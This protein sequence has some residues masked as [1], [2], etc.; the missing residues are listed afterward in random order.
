MLSPCAASHAFW[1]CFSVN[2]MGFPPWARACRGQTRPRGAV[3]DAGDLRVQREETTGEGLR[4]DAVLDG[5]VDQLGVV[6]D[7]ERLHQALLVVLDGARGQAERRADLLR[8]L[9]LGEEPQDLAL[10]RRDGC[11]RVGGIPAAEDF[12]GEFGGDEGA[13]LQ[14]GAQRE[15][16][17]RRRGVL[18]HEA[19]RAGLERAPRVGRV[20][21]HGQEHHAHL[22]VVALELRER[23]DAVQLRHGDVGDDHVG[24]ELARRLYQ[25]A[26]VFHDTG[27]I[28]L[29]RQ[30]AL[31]P[32]GDDAMVVGQQHAGP[33]HAGTHAT[34]VV[35]RPG[36]LSMSSSPRSRRT[37]SRMPARPRLAWSLARAGSKPLPLSLTASCNP[38]RL[39]ESSTVT[40]LACA[41][42]ATLLSA[43]WAT[44]NRQ[45]DVSSG[46]SSGTPLASTS[47]RNAPSRATRSH[48][49][50]SAST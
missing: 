45:S 6:L 46:S 28:E 48:S 39:D 19:G 4:H 23:L 10:P 12:G 7:A 27:E 5:E 47:T 32:L 11:K 15:H 40:A 2:S 26:S 22:R 9:A 36:V 20:A 1:W 3:C 25:R 30:D 44:R 24:P 13:P 17:L 33:A 34:T 43:S 18:Q 38:R 35:P 50:L 42:R 29:L 37:R 14:G 21:V 31:Q 8:R 49:A 16:E 41:W